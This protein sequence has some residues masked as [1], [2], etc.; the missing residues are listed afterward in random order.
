MKKLL[1]LVFAIAL[2]LGVL[3]VGA[4]ADYS[5]APETP[6]GTGTVNNPYKIGTAE[7]LYWFA[8]TVNGGDYDA[9]PS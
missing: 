8:Q 6:D 9:P 4:S 5:G 7:E 2:C 3:C 1:V